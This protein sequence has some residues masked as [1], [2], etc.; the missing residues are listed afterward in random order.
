MV[1]VG[2]KIITANAMPKKSKQSEEQKQKLQQ[3][4]SVLK[5]ALTLDDEEIIKSTIESVIELLEEQIDKWIRGVTDLLPIFNTRI[6]NPV[7]QYFRL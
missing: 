5:L 6:N 7:Y 3:V 1:V 4:V 2:Q